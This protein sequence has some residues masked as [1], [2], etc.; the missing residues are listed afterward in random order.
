[1]MIQA[2]RRRR[3]AQGDEG[4]AMILVMGVVVIITALLVALLQYTTV[5]LK[6]SRNEQ[7][8]QA[9]LT[10]AQAGIDDYIARLNANNV[11]WQSTDCTNLAMKK[12]YTGSTPPCS[13]GAGTA[14][15]WVPIAG[16]TTPT[17][18]PCSVTPTPNSCARFHYDVDATSTI[19][20]GTIAVTAS[21]RSKAITRTI[22]V[23]VRRQ[24]FGDFLYFT[25]YETVDPSNR[26]VY[27]VNNTNAV[28]QCTRHYWDSPARSS[29]CSD[30]VF[31][32]ADTVNGPVHSND[33]IYM[34]GTPNFLGAVTTGYPSCKSSNGTPPP[35][36]SC[37][38]DADG[39]GTVPVFA[40]GIS[41]GG[42][43]PLPP[44]NSALAAQTVASTAY[45][46]PGCAYTGPTRIQ[47]LND[48]TMNVWSP[49]TKTVNSGCGTAPFSGTPQNVQVPN[50]NVIYVNPV[51]SSQATPAAGDCAVG[52]IGGFPQAN[53]YNI[54]L[55]VYDCRAGTALVDGVVKGRVTVGSAGNIIIT[56]DTTYAA[57]TGGADSLGLIAGGSV[58]L[59]HPVQCTTMSNN[60]CTAGNNITPPAGSFA[61]A[62]IQAA[63]LALDH[64][65]QVQLYSL[66]APLTKINVYGSIGQLFRGLVGTNSNGSV[67]HGYAKNYVYD[68]RLKFAPPPF[69]LNPVQ[70]KYIAAVFSEIPPAY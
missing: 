70:A 30:I 46:S 39:A 6:H 28:T 56:G 57:G 34:S 19:A 68:T 4:I 15:T 51:P 44:S 45:G 25:D 67:S 8:T 58:E 69:Y 60:V 24:S 2:L 7:D 3:A 11:Y 17:G 1:M 65:V 14:T 32:S 53:D 20:N 12:A 54:A 38:R 64:S 41:Y 18:S 63:M 21:G 35:T 55:G 59:Y 47:F 42:V 61:V 10:A 5:S 33:A 50:N 31:I 9:A 49:Y 27:G 66:G 43:L 29:G 16:A 52:A 23:S 36:T 37:Y 48:G 22:K 26:F 40:K 13:W 62:D